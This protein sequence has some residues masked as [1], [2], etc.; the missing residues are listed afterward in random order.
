MP[1]VTWWK[2]TNSIMVRRAGRKPTFA[3]PAASVSLG[4]EPPCR[5][6][7]P[8][9]WPGRSLHRP[10]DDPSQPFMDIRSAPASGVATSRPGGNRTLAAS[11]KVPS[12]IGKSGHSSL[13]NRTPNTALRTKVSK[14]QLVTFAKSWF[15][16]AERR[17]H[18]AHA[19]G[20]AAVRR[21]CSPQ[22]PSVVSSADFSRLSPKLRL[23]RLWIRRLGH[24]RSFLP[25][26][27]TV[28][29]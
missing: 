13:S 11:A 25:V 9:S 26:P 10:R 3:R 28:E 18:A 20:E 16:P 23:C 19:L 27:E 14:A 1:G 24:K 8:R 4:S 12:Q 22:I 29:F 2:L 5:D 21:A 6:A 7:A 15:L 17:F